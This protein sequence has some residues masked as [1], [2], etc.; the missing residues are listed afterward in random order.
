MRAK[1]NK[2][3]LGQRVL[4]VA[5]R[6]DQALPYTLIETRQRQ[7]R[8][9]TVQAIEG[10]EVVADEPGIRPSG[11]AAVPWRVRR[12]IDQCRRVKAARHDGDGSRA[13][14]DRLADAGTHH[15]FAR[16]CPVG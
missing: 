13:S 15:G 11:G 12:L 6:S 3:L 2:D 7:A 1:A 4:G 16:Q 8:A 10:A 5:A 9:I 14:L